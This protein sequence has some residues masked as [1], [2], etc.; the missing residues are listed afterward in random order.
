MSASTT[1][2]SR[3]LL[4]GFGN[5]FESEALPGAL[6]KGQNSPQ[7]APYGL[8]AEQLTGSSFTAPRHENLR[9]WLYRI[10]PSVVHGEYQR[11][12][13]NEF[14]NWKTPPFQD[15]V[16]S[17]E[18]RRWNPIPFPQD[19]TTDFVSGMHTVIGNGSPAG[20]HG[21]SAHIYTATASMSTRHFIN[22]D[23]EILLVPQE[24]GI[25][26]RTEFGT[27]LV[28]PLEIALV[29]RGVKFRVELVGARARGYVC[30]NFGAPFRLPG[31]R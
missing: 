22:H 4:A 17:P 12:S 16:V 9:S 11:C 10:R 8:Y 13:P 28:A 31:L 3:P 20:Q 14:S 5:H 2:D 7:K 26:V 29:P 21:V 25:R 19:T 23:A 27:L 1:P 15:A 24:G 30:E 6:P 18:R